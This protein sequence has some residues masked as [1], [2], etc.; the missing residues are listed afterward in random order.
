MSGWVGGWV[1][2]WCVV[3]WYDDDDD[4]KDDVDDDD[5]DDKDERGSAHFCAAIQPADGA[6]LRSCLEATCVVPT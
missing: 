6:L 1:G 2:G 5:N 3:W 4:E